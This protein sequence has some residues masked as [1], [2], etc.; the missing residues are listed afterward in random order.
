MAWKIYVVIFTV[1]NL[2]TLVFFQY[3]TSP[4]QLLGAIT[5]ILDLALNVAAFSYAFRKPV[6]SK[7]VLAWI[8][9]INVGLFG[10]FLL[11]EFLAF[12]QEVF[13]SGISL[14]TSGFVSII[15]NIPALPALYLTYMLAYAKS[16]QPKKK[17]KK[18]A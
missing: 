8:F 15:A 10:L 6:L 5:L 11:F 13:G 16:P 14:P 1:L 17:S 18:K 7:Y 3:G 9:K 4:D 2:F 12:L